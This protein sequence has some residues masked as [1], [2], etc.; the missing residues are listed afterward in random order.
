MILL[1]LMACSD[2]DFGHVGRAL[3]AYDRG[4][5]SMRQ[6]NPAAAASAFS[7]AIALDPKRPILRSW[8]AKALID[9]GQDE[10]ALS[11]LNDGLSR[12][13]AN[14]RM[15]HQ[16]AALLARGGSLSE[17]AKDLRWLYAHD[18]AHPILIGED[19]DFVAL[20]TDSAYAELVPDARVDASV[21]GEVGSV[22][23]GDIYSIEFSI[24]SRAGIPIQITN[25]GQSIEWL[26]LQRI[27][28]D[29]TSNTELWT[30]RRVRMEYRALEPG[31]VVAGP[32]LVEVA[33][34]RALTE[35]LVVE[36]VAIPGQKEVGSSRHVTFGV[37]STRW[38]ASDLPLFITDNDGDW[39]VFD[40]GMALSAHTAKRGPRMEYREN[41]QPRWSAHLI[42]GGPGV[43]I[44]TAGESVLRWGDRRE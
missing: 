13:P 23:V 18:A 38:K 2:P 20:K 5:V 34:S 40:S 29:V 19:P 44:R 9:A 37:P 41:G 33:D 43:E 12:F 14:P 35:Q 28:E 8:E 31:R 22:L 1:W 21:A 24:T 25:Q 3:E 17:S 26:G 30:Q 27:V 4:I 11:R 36:A 39:A 15:R 10:R 6:G 16:R 42:E 32:W 7:E